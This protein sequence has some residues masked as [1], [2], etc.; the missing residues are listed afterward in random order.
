MT[1]G[2][3]PLEVTVAVEV[4]YPPIVNSARVG[5]VF[6]DVESG[7]GVPISIVIGSDYFLD[8]EGQP[9][10]YSASLADGS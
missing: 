8:P 9:L 5:T 10:T 2:I 4:N 6:T 3:N 1:D 7:V